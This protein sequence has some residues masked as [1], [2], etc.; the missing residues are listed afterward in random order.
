MQ[1]EEPRTHAEKPSNR[2][3]PFW[4]V[5]LGSGLL[6]GLLSAFCGEL[7]FAALHKE[8]DYPASFTSLS[9]SERAVARAV[10]RYNTRMAVDTNKAMAA[11]GLLGVAL[12]VAMG[13]AG[14]LAGPSRRADL[15]GALGGGV[16][17]GIAGAALSMALVPLFFQ[18]SDS[19][20]TS[21]PL[22]FATDA[23]IFA[24]VAA[25]ASAAL[26]WEWGDRKVIVRC[27]IG[28][29][30]G[31]VVATLVALV[32]NV[33]AFG[34]MRIFEPVPAKSMARILVH[35]FVAVGAALGAVVGSRKFRA[36]LR[37]QGTD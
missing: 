36:R 12:G 10:V 33:A 19:G 29:V 28:G 18:L 14:G 23:A 13:L 3:F 11:Y 4:L 5:A 21:L 25:A 8:P 2:V 24:G 16:M 9:S 37:M 31:A 6:A 1:L 26:A 15:R 22:L 27:M 30:V 17:G 34:I 7:T 20:I 35:V 32:I